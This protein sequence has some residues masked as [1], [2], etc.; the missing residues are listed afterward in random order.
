MKRVC[1]SFITGICLAGLI[2]LSITGISCM[3]EGKE[4]KYKKYFCTT[5]LSWGKVSFYDLT[6]TVTKKPDY[7]D[8]RIKGIT[9]ADYTVGQSR[10][11]SLPD[12]GLITSKKAYSS[13]NWTFWYVPSRV[14]GA[15]RIK[16]RYEDRHLTGEKFITFRYN[17]DIEGL[18]IAY[19][20]AI[21]LND[22]PVW[23]KNNYHPV[24]TSESESPDTHEHIII[25]KD[26]GEIKLRLFKRNTNLPKNQDITIPSNLYGYDLGIPQYQGGSAKIPMY[27]III[28][29][30]EKPES[31]T[32]VPADPKEYNVVLNKDASDK[33]AVT[34]ARNQA[35]IDIE[36]S[37]ESGFWSTVPLIGKTTCT[38][39]GLMEGLEY[40]VHEASLSTPSGLSGSSHTSEI[41]INSASSR[42]KLEIEGDPYNPSLSGEIFFRYLMDKD[43]IFREMHI[44]RMTVYSDN[45]LGT[46]AGHLTD[47]VIDLTEP[48]AAYENDPAPFPIPKQP[49]GE[50][51]IPSDKFRC[52]TNLDVDG[53]KTALATVNSDT[54]S[55]EVDNTAKTIRFSG[56]LSTKLEINGKEVTFTADVAI[57][58]DFINFP[59]RA[60]GNLEST[61]TVECL[62]SWNSESVILDASGSFDVYD[63]AGKTITYQWFKD[64][65]TP[66]EIAYKKGKRVILPISS[67][68]VGIHQFTVVA[69]DKHG[70]VDTDMIQVE[71][72]DET[73][74]VLIAPTDRIRLV[75]TPDQCPAS[76]GELGQPVYGDDCAGGDVTVSNDAPASLLFPEGESIVTWKAEDG[77]GNMT[78]KEQ[79]VYVIV[80]EHPNWITITDITSRVSGSIETITNSINTQKGWQQPASVDLTPLTQTLEEVAGVVE[81]M[82]LEGR[83][84]MRGQILEKLT[85]SASRLN[86]LSVMLENFQVVESRDMQPV[87]SHV[88]RELSAVREALSDIAAQEE[89]DDTHHTPDEPARDVPDIHRSEIPAPLKTTPFIERFDGP[90]EARWDLEE[91]WRIDRVEGNL[92]LAG[93]GP[94][95]RAQLNAG[96]SW[97]DYS[98]KSRVKVSSGKVHISYR[99]SEGGRYFISHSG[100]KLILYKEAP[101]GEISGLAGSDHS[102]RYNTWHTI[103]IRGTGGHIQVFADGRPEPVID[104]T[105]NDPLIRG[106][107]AFEKL[108]DS[109]VQVDYIDIRP[110]TG[111]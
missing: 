35:L 27:I 12:A 1:E 59:P 103:E 31:G 88:T 54:L 18:Y 26:Q 41:Q 105:D 2:G 111:E 106:T 21:K 7:Y 94:P 10:K 110:G 17:N 78:E 83:E 23:L 57:V 44:E 42:A 82:E 70:L 8:T 5:P 14:I 108:E 6:V 29:P 45:L 74:P 73:P 86:D 11:P 40:G 60:R 55:I 61:R 72:Q 95:S 64:Y 58:G 66:L 50:Y 15:A 62:D 76:V 71:V 100:G 99:V 109:Y 85:E 96:E 9:S 84:H 97:T 32:S 53:D 51:I 16:P 102:M 46:K 49:C 47:I 68:S 48:V 92:V 56:K 33:D 90:A 107:V 93:E 79:K 3:P 89:M 4:P 75:F 36:T 28:K 69:T 81:T 67:L 63:P 24:K 91:G 80:L 98:F 30:K 101:R 34:E 38:F 20:W 65:R 87:L 22:L 52:Y 77:H 13:H 104:I 39:K 25:K 37:G 19:D 43:N